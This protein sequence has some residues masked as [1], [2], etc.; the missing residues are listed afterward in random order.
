MSIRHK[1][2]GY[3][4]FV[5]FSDWFDTFLFLIPPREADSSCVAG[6]DKISDRAYK[7]EFLSKKFVNHWDKTFCYP[8]NI[9]FSAMS[10]ALSRSTLSEAVLLG[11]SSNSP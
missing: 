3:F 11:K 9:G 8:S 10:N 4:S 1:G 2:S 5:K 7:S 6:A